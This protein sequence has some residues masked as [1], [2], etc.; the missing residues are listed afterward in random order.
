MSNV[1]LM[2][3]IV[4]PVISEKS[5]RIGDAHKQFVFKVMPYANKPL[6]KTA[7]EHLFN[8]K[9]KSVQIANLP[10][11]VKRFGNHTGKRS[12]YKKAYV[13]LQEG[14]DID[15]TMSEDK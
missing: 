8:V 10:G 7:V 1:E 6:V 5:T 13:S 12:G 15:F 9:V 14:F 11:K 2:N 3:V 4:A